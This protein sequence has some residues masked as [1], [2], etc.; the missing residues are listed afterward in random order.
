MIISQYFGNPKL[1][2]NLGNQLFELAALIGLAKRYST[3]L[4][5]PSLWQY[6]SSFNLDSSIE[7]GDV[8]AFISIREPAFHC[9]MEFFDKFE[10][11]IK[12]ERVYVEGYFQSELYWKPFEYEI[13][14]AFDFTAS[15]QKDTDLFLIDND[16]DVEGMVAV[17]VRR[18]DFA[19]DS[20]HYLLPLEYYFGALSLFFP[21]K[22]IMVFS[23]D[24]PW[25]KEH[26]NITD[27]RVVFSENKSAIEQLSLM[28]RFSNF[29]LA[30][31]TFSW[32]G[33][34]LSKAENK[35]VIRP[36]YHFG[37]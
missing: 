3:T 1:G 26:F 33:A 37:G 35:K 2:R 4:L 8:E 18:G 14:K 29:I 31:S 16:V 5:M 28:C 34:Y 24:I 19:T 27:R 22:D 25:C 15:I 9:C 32:W 17:S 23:D 6:R 36:Y 30:N 20:N 11:I 7:Y 10:N 21:E 12:N 13:R